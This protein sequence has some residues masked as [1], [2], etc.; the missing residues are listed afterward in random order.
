PM[1]LA[2]F[3][4]LLVAIVLLALCESFLRGLFPFNPDKLFNT[5][6]H[7]QPHYHHG[8]QGQGQ[9]LSHASP[10]ARDGC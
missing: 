10:G 6:Y 5:G 3:P 2:L 9:L 1:I 8:P 4:L 7:Q